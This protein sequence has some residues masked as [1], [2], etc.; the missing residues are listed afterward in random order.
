MFD[1]LF[2]Q[3]NFNHLILEVYMKH[4]CVVCGIFDIDIAFA[5]DE[6]C[7][8]CYQKT[9]EYEMVYCASEILSYMN[10]FKKYHKFSDEEKVLFE[11][12]KDFVEKKSNII[13][14]P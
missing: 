5:T 12:F 13:S 6:Y 9:E 4:E 2:K 7:V 10:H 3:F 8:D 11:K 1:L 14:K